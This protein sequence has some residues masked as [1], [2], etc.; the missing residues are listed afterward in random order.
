[1]L[2]VSVIW[3]T[4]PV[5]VIVVGVCVWAIRRFKLPFVPGVYFKVLA[6]VAALVAI[7]WALVLNFSE[8]ETTNA[9]FGGTIIS[10]LIFTYLIHL[11]IIPID[12]AF[13]EESTGDE[14]EPHADGG[15]SEA[16]RES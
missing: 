14:H 16:L 5:V 2:A 15:G 7:V 9:D 12:D 8:Y 11:W 6:V 1:M 13:P 10:S 3:K 4:L